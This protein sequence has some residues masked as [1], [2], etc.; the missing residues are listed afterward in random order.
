LTLYIQ[1]VEQINHELIAS[2]EQRGRLIKQT[3]E[4]I[5]TLD[6]STQAQVNQQVELRYGW[7]KDERDFAK[8]I[9]HLEDAKKIA[10]AYEGW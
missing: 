6:D 3:Q 5:A 4:I 1:Q 9:A 10:S 2:S 8:A 7:A